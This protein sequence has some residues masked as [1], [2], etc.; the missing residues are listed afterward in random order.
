VADVDSTTAEKGDDRNSRLSPP[1]RRTFEF[2]AFGTPQHRETLDRAT[3]EKSV[4]RRWTVTSSR[5]SILSARGSAVLPVVRPDTFGAGSGPASEVGGDLCRQLPDKPIRHRANVSQDLRQFGG[6]EIVPDTGEVE[7]GRDFDRH[8]LGIFT[9][10][11]P[12]TGD[13]T[14]CQPSGYRRS[15]DDPPG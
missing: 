2:H 9:R 13:E 7:Q 3:A 11:K 15:R 4:M 8:M 14:I 5:R 6:T 1:W 10:S 12:P